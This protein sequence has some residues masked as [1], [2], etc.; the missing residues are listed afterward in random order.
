MI[1]SVPFFALMAWRATK[2]SDTKPMRRFDWLAILWLGFVGYY[3]ASL[4][5]FMGLQYVTAAL[6][7]LVVFL[8]PTMVVLLSVV[9]FRQRIVARTALALV[10]SYAG[11]LLVFAHDIRFTGAEHALSLGG[12]L[13]FGGAFCHALDL[14][15]TGPIIAR[16]GSLRFIAWAMLVS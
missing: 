16:L 5:D 11:I 9:L 4:L 6:E 1:Y 8:Y 10:I 12:G 15:G 3:L 7:R 2:S 14:V 13:V